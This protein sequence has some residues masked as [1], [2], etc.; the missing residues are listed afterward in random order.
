M[1]KHFFLTI[2]LGAAS[3]LGAQSQVDS[4]AKPA[5]YDVVVLRGGSRLTGTIIK[6]ELERG[7]EFRLATGA[8]M[9]IP[10]NEI[11]QVFQDITLHPATATNYPRY[12]DGPRQPRPYA[13]REHG[14][15]QSFS[16]FLNFA[17]PGGA[18]LQYTAGHRFS[19]MLGVGA[20]IGIESND[21]FNSR[22]AVPLFAEARGFLVKERISP[23][24]AVKLGYAFAL[25]DEFS[26][27]IEAKGGAYF[28]PDFGV[29]FGSRA[30]NYYLG[31]EYKIMS[32]T[33]VNDF[34][35]G[36]GTSTDKVTYRRIELRTGLFF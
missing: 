19:R 12:Y 33:Y 22:D 32:A 18:G 2:L 25:K 13:F 36:D 31:L 7:M 30:V 3:V 9:V 15:Y 6:W 10:K 21:F 35:W 5:I 28:S 26:S 14:F 34:G 17:D 8:L 29:R 4:I 23:Y 24:Y 11:N 20:G 16:L 27:E 1:L